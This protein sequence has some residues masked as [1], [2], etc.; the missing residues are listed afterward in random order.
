LPYVSNVSI[1][2]LKFVIAAF[3]S[4]HLPD[5]SLTWELV[6]LEVTL[7]PLPLLP[8]LPEDDKPEP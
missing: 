7:Y 5:E 2:L 6:P 1:L 8:L 3:G 4:S